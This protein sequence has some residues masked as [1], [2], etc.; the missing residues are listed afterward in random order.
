MINN[1]SPKRD[2][3][4]EVFTSKF[5]Y[6]VL[7]L[8][9]SLPPEERYPTKIGE[10]ELDS[11]AQTV[12]NYLKGFR[13][14]GIIG[15]LRKEGRKQLYEIKFDD[16]YQF[17]I[18]ELSQRLSER[19][20][21]FKKK[22]EGDNLPADPDE[23]I[24]INLERK[25]KEE[26]PEKLKSLD[27]EYSGFLNRFFSFYV[28]NYLEWVKDSTLE[29]MFFENLQS[30]II[31]FIKK[32]GHDPELN[33]SKVLK[34][35]HEVYLTIGPIDI[36]LLPPLER[37]VINSELEGKN[38]SIGEVHNEYQE[39]LIEMEEER[40]ERGLDKIIRSEEDLKNILKKI[41]EKTQDD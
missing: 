10:E 16:F 36:Y 17:W 3:S 5:A 33:S 2:Y 4:E 15:F 20:K 19:R 11:S 12:S 32:V 24:I 27:R 28:G 8:L 7:R 29:K 40:G 13:K 1:M 34:K 37:F 21:E 14:L 18:E 35:L 6:K 31:N 38:T 9:N 26:G 23:N 25:R 22:E 41:E 30:Y 39:I